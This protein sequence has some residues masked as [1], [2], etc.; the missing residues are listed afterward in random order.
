MRKLDDSQVESFDTEYAFGNRWDTVKS[1]ID[2]DFP[3]GR[4]RFLD[5]GGGNGV[6]TDT[7]LETYPNSNGTLLDNSEKLLSRNRKNERKK[8]VCASVEDLAA[9]D[10]RFDVVFVHWLLHHLIGN[11]YVET[12]RNQL[13]TL[14]N[15]AQ[16]LTERGRI[17][18]FENTCNGWLVDNLP[19]WLIFQISS[20][21]AIAPITRRMGANTAGV[22]VCYLS[23]DQW[24][25]TIQRSG[26]RVLEY[27][28]PD[29]RHPRLR[30]E[31]RT[32]LHVRSL[33]VGHFWLSRAA[34]S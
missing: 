5:L 27:T 6:F 19:G 18:V 29:T 30:I 20:A 3:H 7:V 22:G 10:G 9:L 31:W 13:V 15:L 14:A 34:S 33:R 2:K 17:S 4:F 28:E 26:L 16:Y 21:K 25:S 8:L 32:L 11:S 12:R 23:K 1:R 24:L